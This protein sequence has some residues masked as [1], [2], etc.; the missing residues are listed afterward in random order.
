MVRA[1]MY[2]AICMEGKVYLV[3]TNVGEDIGYQIYFPLKL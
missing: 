1:K 2:A 3:V